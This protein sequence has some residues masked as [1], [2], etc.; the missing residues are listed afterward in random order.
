M[1]AEKHVIIKKKNKEGTNPRMP[2]FVPIICSHSE[3]I[4]HFTF[5]EKL[6]EVE[7]IISNQVSGVICE[8]VYN[9][10]D[11][12]LIMSVPTDLGFYTIYIATKD[13]EIYLG[14]YTI[15]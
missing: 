1:D 5:E 9:S 8:Y 7:I 11:V 13:D 12:N 4:L 6:G 10:E 15:Y 14:E 3:G 2:E